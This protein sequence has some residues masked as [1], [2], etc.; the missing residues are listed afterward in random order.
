MQ[1]EAL[2]LQRIDALLA[3]CDGFKERA[4][5]FAVWQG[6]R[7]VDG[8]YRVPKPVYAPDVTAFF[9]ELDQPCW[10]EPNFTSRQAG[11]WLDHPY[12]IATADLPRVRSM[13]TYCL[14]GEAQS[15]GH[16]ARMLLS[17]KLV[18]VLQRL[19]QLRDEKP[20]SLIAE[21]SFAKR[22]QAAAAD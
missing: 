8:S 7:Q 19:R 10:H 11:N 16:W 20:Q 18:A 21:A 17:G 9:C 1:T 14:Q 12:F 15:A 6:G 5:P 22:G 2:T 13:L 3:Y 4:R